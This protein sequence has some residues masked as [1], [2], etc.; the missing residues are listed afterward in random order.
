MVNKRKLSGAL[1]SLW[2]LV[3]LV[4]AAGGCAIAQRDDGGFV[5]GIPMTGQ[6]ATAA[7]IGKAAGGVLGALGVPGGGAIGTLIAQVAA[8]AGIGAAAHYRAKRQGEDTGYEYAKATY[9]PPPPVRAHTH[10]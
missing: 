7:D 2:L 4:L 10:A 1:V 5:L 9:A 8:T 3:L 6:G